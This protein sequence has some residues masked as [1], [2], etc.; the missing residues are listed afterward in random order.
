[1]LFPVAMGL[2]PLPAVAPASRMGAVGDTEHGGSAMKITGVGMPLVIGLCLAVLAVACDEGEEGLA[3]ATPSPAAAATATPLATPSPEPS[4]TP[5]LEPPTP[6]VRQPTWTVYQLSS[7]GQIQ[8]MLEDGL[9]AYTV[10]SVDPETAKFEK[11]EIAFVADV[12]ADGVDDAIVT[13]FTGGAHCCFEYLIFS[14]APEGIRLDD[15]FSIGNAN[16]TDVVDLDGDG[17]P[18]LQTYDD[19]LAYFPDLC[20]ACSPFLP[21]VLCR[22]VQDVYYDCTPQFPGLLEAAAEEFEARL[23]DAVQQQQLEEYE[24]LSPALGLRA[25]YLRMGL[26]E[27]SWSSVENLCPECNVWLSDNFSDL[28]ERLSWVQPSRGE[29]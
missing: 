23:R 27:E 7:A 5:T 25:S 20:Y 10:A 11:W 9:N 15:W 24:K 19:R 29:Q 14:E 12:N 16:I 13:H 18:E 21:L 26:G 2:L 22:S 28:Q 17:V 1:M 3:T 6:Q 4:P 8:I